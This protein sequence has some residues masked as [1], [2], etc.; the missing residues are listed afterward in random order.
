MLKRPS[1]GAMMTFHEV[2]GF[3]TCVQMQFL[4]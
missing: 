4:P 2:I 1:M 3:I